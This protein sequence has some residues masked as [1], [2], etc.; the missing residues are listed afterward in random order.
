MAKSH[1]TAADKNL[2]LPSPSFKRVE[3][4]NAKQIPEGSELLSWKNCSFY[5]DG[6]TVRVLDHQG[7]EDT[8]F[9]ENE[10][11]LE[12]T[13]NQW[14]EKE[15]LTLPEE[16]ED[17][18]TISI[19]DSTYGNLCGVD[20]LEGIDPTKAARLKQ[21]INI[22]TNNSGE[23]AVS[24][25]VQSQFVPVRT[26]AILDDGKFI[27]FYDS[28]GEKIIFKTTNEQGQ[29]EPP[30][31]WKRFTIFNYEQD[32][33]LKSIYGQI[34]GLDL[35]NHD[36]VALDGRLLAL[37]NRNGVKVVS[38]NNGGNEFLSD[39]IQN[40]AVTKSRDGL[41]Y[42]DKEKPEY[43]YH[44]TFNHEDEASKNAI[45][46][47][48]EIRNSKVKKIKEVP[49]G[50]II[51][52]LTEEG[53]I[54]FIGLHDGE[55]LFQYDGIQDFTTTETQVQIIDDQGNL[56]TCESNLSELSHAIRTI[57]LTSSIDIASIVSG[58]EETPN[59]VT[60][61]EKPVLDEKTKEI[62][63]GLGA[64]IDEAKTIEDFGGIEKSIAEL[65]QALED[66]GV[67][68]VHVNYIL[69][70][71]FD[72]IET[73]K[74]DRAQ[75]LVNE[76]GPK[77]KAASRPSQMDELT[78]SLRILQNFNPVLA[79]GS[80][81]KRDVEAVLSNARS[82]RESLYTTHLSGLETDLAAIVEQVESEIDNKKTYEAYMVWHRNERIAH[83]RSMEE[84]YKQ[85]SQD[86]E[87]AR[88]AILQS[89]ET[90]HR[91]CAEKIS[92]F[93]DARGE[94][95]AEAESALMRKVENVK[96]DINNYFETL[97]N[98]SGLV[99]KEEVTEFIAN[100]PAFENITAG[101]EDIRSENVP[102]AQAL[103][104]DISRKSYEVINQIIAR[105]NA[106]TND[107]GENVYTF[108]HINAPIM[109]RVQKGGRKSARL[110]FIMNQ[111]TLTDNPKTAMGDIG[112]TITNEKGELTQE[113]L[114]GDTGIE[115]EFRLGA[116][117]KGEE[118]TPGYLPRKQYKHISRLLNEW[119][120]GGNVKKEHDDLRTRLKAKYAEKNERTEPSEEHPEGELKNPEWKQQYTTLY[121]QYAEF[122]A[123]NFIPHLRQAERKLNEINSSEPV[124]INGVPK[125][126]PSWVIGEEEQGY[127][128]DIAERFQMQ[129]DRQ[130]G[131]LMLKGHTG[132]GKDVLLQ[133]FAH[134]TNRS[135]FSFDCSKWTT[136][137]DLGEEILL[138][139]G[140]T[141]KVPSSIVEGIQTPGAI[142]YFNEFNAMPESAQIFLHSLLDG[143]RQ[144]TLKTSG[145][146]VIKT[147]PSVVIAGSMNP[148]YEG[149]FDPQAATKSRMQEIEI[150][151][152]HLRRDGKQELG[153]SPFDR[154]FASSEALKIARS[155]NSLQH[156]TYNPDLSENEF[157]KVW[158]KYV[159][160]S[161]VPG[162][163]D[164]DEKQQFDM[165]VILELVKM[166]DVIRYNFAQQYVNDKPTGFE[167]NTDIL[168]IVYP[169]T[170]RDITRCAY[171]LSNFVEASATDPRSVALDLLK[172]EYLSHYDE[173]SVREKLAGEIARAADNI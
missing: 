77:I 171:R 156:L 74:T 112:I 85:T 138:E 13:I 44:V 47:P 145:G 164:A 30:H 126:N 72:E 172:E 159:N 111:A 14:L 23:I 69:K 56:K 100:D 58:S 64:Q 108:G 68:E 118:I 60:D 128:E 42:C 140:N 165:Q 88:L 31:N 5:I 136:E 20:Q 120:N 119:M 32:E 38:L 94:A 130:E 107:R 153:E 54:Y 87:Q 48:E 11:K 34:D 144:M 18:D 98:E 19:I 154:K 50:E 133:V 129:A 84:H 151:Y 36:V 40:P 99:T 76:V 53:K 70:P 132:T 173:A 92:S 160:R 46:L 121:K 71:I 149:T 135:Y 51:N 27:I 8:S 141:V 122:C 61:A 21:L 168:D 162:A 113:R 41:S 146:K 73:K 55:I 131:M 62:R 155:T 161:Q 90:I 89:Q 163:I 29:T 22:Q 157:V 66:G 152:N 134:H 139:D 91:I 59:E 45:R 67:T 114:W 57:R 52:I 115:Q 4:F 12:Y 150:E 101:I 63:D 137:A 147:E 65:K 79:E 102:Q 96:L 9:T 117:S 143:K 97:S 127:L 86:G 39:N 25:L 24:Q 10:L 103:E 49:G 37:V 95:R 7:I 1:E 6:S 116:D 43:L 75:A 142:V 81:I 17:A 167:S 16:K 166:A 33:D 170:L 105:Q 82:H 3:D 148:G 28:K 123:Q 93:K 124:Y 125:L 158:D 78:P 169:I 109:K 15:G 83:L 110:D 2:G 26:P 35:Q 106:K 80:T 104:S